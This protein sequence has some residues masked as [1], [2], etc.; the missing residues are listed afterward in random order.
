M[1][2][3]PSG[4]LDATSPLPLTTTL[5]SAPSSQEKPHPAPLRI[6]SSPPAPNVICDQQLLSSGAI[7]P[8]PTP[9]ATSTESSP[10]SARSSPR[11]RTS[12]EGGVEPARSGVLEFPHHILDYDLRSAT[13]LGSGL[14]SDVYR[15]R[16]IPAIPASSTSASPSSSADP[17]AAAP[18][19]PLTPTKHRHPSLSSTPPP[20]PTAYA[21]KL[22]TSRTAR[23]V[24]KSEAAILSTLTPLPGSQA[25]IV[26]FHGLD[27]RNS[28][29]VLTAL[30][31]SLDAFVTRELNPLSEASRAE[32]LSAAWPALARGLA[33]GLE[34][35]QAAGCVH[36][37]VKPGNVLLRRGHDGPGAVFADFSAAAIVV[38]ASS[39]SSPG[40]GDAEG[41]IGGGGAA[42]A[43]GNGPDR[44]P[45][46]PRGG[47]TWDFLCPSLLARPGSAAPSPATDLY[48]LAVTLLFAVI[49][50]SPFDAAGRN[51]W[52]RREMAKLGRVLECA[53]SGDDGWRSEARLAALAKSC[54]WDV[55]AW[56]AM[57][58]RGVERRVGIR[59]WR[60]ALE[61][62]R[63][64]VV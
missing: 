39:S 36:G 40:N 35:L 3:S 59:E 19:P 17:A 48:A 6:A 43:L 64:S 12:T 38:G 50:G 7:T 53:F 20:P 14:W 24:L 49:G 25:C 27:P 31:T 42:A 8:P 51:V 28:A 32:Q 45:A 22:P 58:L 37:D 46:A 47:G 33:R 60:E 63:K 11:G 21:I 57:G 2:A 26:P 5:S 62:D 34:W 18:T 23:A 54:G 13:I 10:R 56:L 29:L 4:H 44:H 15:A 16:P 41:G 55:R 1:D 52:R 9:I 30:P 61:R